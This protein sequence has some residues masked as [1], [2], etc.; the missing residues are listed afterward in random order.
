AGL[1][2]QVGHLNE[3]IVGLI[4]LVGLITIALS[5]YLILYSQKIYELIAPTLSIF[6]RKDPYREARIKLNEQRRYDLII[7]GLGRF[8][9]KIADYLDQHPEVNYLGIDFDPQVVKQWQEAGKDVFYGDIEDPD[10]L[11][12]IPYQKA[13]CVVSTIPER[14]YSMQL[15]KS[16][17]ENDFKGKIFLTAMNEKD[18]ELLSDCNADSILM[19]H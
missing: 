18:L 16:L 11:E 12:H 5:T 8:G 6:E 13:R 3:D 19:P 7:F 15:I 17:R 1:G 9:G 4:T 10:I 14:D 2:L